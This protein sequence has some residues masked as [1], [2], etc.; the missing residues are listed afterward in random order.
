MEWARSAP[1]KEI[2]LVILYIENFRKY[3]LIGSVRNISS[4][5]GT[6]KE[7]M[8]K[9]RRE[10]DKTQE[11]TFRVVGSLDYLDC[12]MVL[13]VYVMSEIMKFY[14]ISASYYVSTIR[15]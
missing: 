2:T 4:C 9:G 12:V 3:K 5:Q 1:P 13:Q 10:E 6:G 11:E 15:Q 14:T 7:R 8:E